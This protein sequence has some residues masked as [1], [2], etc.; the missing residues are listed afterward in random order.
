MSNS[1]ACN[2]RPFIVECPSC[3]YGTIFD[4]MHSLVLEDAVL[5]L[6]IRFDLTRLGLSPPHWIVSIETVTS[7]RRLRTIFLY[8]PAMAVQTYPSNLLIQRLVDQ[9][10]LVTEFMQPAQCPRYLTTLLSSWQ[11]KMRHLSCSHH[12]T[13]SEI[14]QLSGISLS[15]Y[16]QPSV[17]FS[18]SL[19]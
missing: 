13:R 7:N 10:T 17:R 2:S 6:G 4:T 15:A 19:R 16:D 3:W 8:T 14:A 9:I 5:V 1:K 12:R 11:A 18:D